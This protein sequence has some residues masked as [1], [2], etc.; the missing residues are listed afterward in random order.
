MA[1]EFVKIRSPFGAEGTCPRRALEHYL[2][3]GYTLVDEPS[4][5]TA[6]PA[7]STRTAPSAEGKPQ[8]TRPARKRPAR[9]RA[10]KKQ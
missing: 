2:A 8:R 6:T 4:A 7:E 5:G 10:A 9:K 3:K 1:T